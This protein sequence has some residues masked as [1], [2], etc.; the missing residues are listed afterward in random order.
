MYKFEETFYVVE[1]NHTEG[2]LICILKN[3][4]YRLYLSE[5]SE[6]NELL[7]GYHFNKGE[8]AVDSNL[9]GQGCFTRPII[10]VK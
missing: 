10:T 5:I 7:W 1:N 6:A 9:C 2:R 8:S 4:S 3:F